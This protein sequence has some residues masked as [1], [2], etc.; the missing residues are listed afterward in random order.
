MQPAEAEAIRL[1]FKNI[2]VPVP[3]VF[4]TNF[5]FNYGNI[6]M[7]LIPGSPLEMKWDTLDEKSKES[8][9]LQVWDLVSKIQTISCPSELK[10]LF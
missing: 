4:F 8:V 1:V 6:E 3:E 5:S 2:P 10:G 9:C 7:T